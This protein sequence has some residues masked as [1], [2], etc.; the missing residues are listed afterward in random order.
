MKKRLSIYIIFALLTAFSACQQEGFES[1]IKNNTGSVNLEY[2]FNMPKLLVNSR[3]LADDPRNANG[4]WSNWDKLVDGQLFYRLTIFLVNESTN[5]LVA[6]RDYYNGSND[7]KENREPEG[8]NGF[9]LNGAVDKNADMAPTAKATF[10]SAYPMH[11]ERITAGNYTMFAVAN[12]S[13]KTFTDIDGVSKSYGGL[14]DPQDLEGTTGMDFTAIVDGIITAF[15]SSPSGIT[16]FTTTYA[17]LLNYKLNSGDDRI[18]AQVP[19]PLV[20]VKRSIELKAG[21][22]YLSGEMSRTYARVRLV[23]TNNTDKE[24]AATGFSFKENFASQQAYLFNDVINDNIENN[25]N[26]LHG[27]FDLY[28]SSKGNIYSFSP[29]AV[30][31]FLNAD[32]RPIQ[33][34]ESLTLFDAYI[35]EGKNINNFAYDANGTSGKPTFSDA[36]DAEG[37]II[38]KLAQVI[39][40]NYN[41]LYNYFLIETDAP[42]TSEVFHDDGNSNDVLVCDTIISDSDQQIGKVFFQHGQIFALENWKYIKTAT[43]GDLV[44]SC[45]IRSVRTNKYLYNADSNNAIGTINNSS[46]LQFTETPTTMY[47]SDNPQ[48]TGEDMGMSISL[49]EDEN[50]TGVVSINGP[51]TYWEWGGYSSN[52]KFKLR[53]HPVEVQT[54]DAPKWEL[55][56]PIDG[57]TITD[58]NGNPILANQDIVRNEFFTINLNFTKK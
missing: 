36:T 13:P 23:M 39:D 35:L 9:Y 17:N 38:D 58:A 48:N 10:L 11:N 32:N 15:T 47:I 20:L 56:K 24:M 12:Y 29:D 6:Y 21:N 43:N 37:K 1:T 8:G 51:K 33:V 50:L 53:L 40:E 31:S 25:A 55:S 22:N 34:G 54:I 45:Q 19:Q 52:R 42:N 5:T 46:R 41:L 28:E 7:N 18:C 49:A 26:P 30:S 3:S 57:T 14:S 27:H 4:T 2:T 44:F 16:N